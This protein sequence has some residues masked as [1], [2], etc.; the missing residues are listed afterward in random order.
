M[1]D[2]RLKL[3]TC[4]SG[5]TRFDMAGVAG[6]TGGMARQTVSVRVGVGLAELYPSDGIL[7]APAS[8]RL[9]HQLI[10]DN[11]ISR[12]L[13]RVVHHRG[14][15]IVEFE[16]RVRVRVSSNFSLHC[17]SKKRLNFKTV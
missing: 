11:I 2:G 3:A 17:V 10:S 15:K 6:H 9:C 13:P 4:N 8:P 1:P 12:G 16:F 14:F 5:R 7:R